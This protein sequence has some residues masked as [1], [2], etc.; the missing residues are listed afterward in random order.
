[1]FCLE[2]SVRFCLSTSCSLWILYFCEGFNENWSCFFGHFST[3]FPQNSFPFF[4]NTQAPGSA[5][6]ASYL[7]H[8]V[9]SHPNFSHHHYFKGLFW[10]SWHECE[11]KFCCIGNSL[12]RHICQHGEAESSDESGRSS[13][14]RALRPVLTAANYLPGWWVLFC[15]QAPRGRTSSSRCTKNINLS[16]RFALSVMLSYKQTSQ[17]PPFSLHCLVHLF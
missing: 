11:S 9:L 1:M 13:G 14:T 6:H 8:E 15:T 2:S 16:L 3:K 7:V 17:L 4:S 12:R 10:Y 5:V